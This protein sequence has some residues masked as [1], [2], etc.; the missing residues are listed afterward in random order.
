MITSLF[1]RENGSANGGSSENSTSLSPENASLDG[2][3][4]EEQFERE[5]GGPGERL[6][7][8]RLPANSAERTQNKPPPPPPPPPS[9]PESASAPIG[10]RLNRV[11]PHGEEAIPSFNNAP[12]ETKTP[13]DDEVEASKPMT[14][15]VFLDD[16]ER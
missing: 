6:L 11:F 9:A 7:K 4:G 12:S 13:S 1:Y 5:L 2:M 15:S 16:E 8:D 3:E 14:R 10:S